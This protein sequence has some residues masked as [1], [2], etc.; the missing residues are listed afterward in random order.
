MN[1]G[2][3]VTNCYFSLDRLYNSAGE[4]RNTTLHFLL[5]LPILIVL[6][7]I[8]A[9][10]AN[11]STSVRTLQCKQDNYVKVRQ[12]FNAVVSELGDPTGKTFDEISSLSFLARA[13]PQ[14]DD[15]QACAELTASMLNNTILN[16]TLFTKDC[17]SE[18]FSE[19]WSKDP[20]CN[21]ECALFDFL[22]LPFTFTTLIY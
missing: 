19:E 12:G 14:S 17:F 7:Q 2:L 9:Q 6:P 1:E 8:I 22:D 3:D 16:E 21:P 15:W 18:K 5:S 13:Y 20:C 4:V 11:V 10:N